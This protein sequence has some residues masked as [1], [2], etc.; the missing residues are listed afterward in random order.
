[1]EKEKSS[2]FEKVGI[3]IYAVVVFGTILVGTGFLIR[4][5]IRVI[6]K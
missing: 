1:M 4:N 2:W 5:I 3:T 6:M